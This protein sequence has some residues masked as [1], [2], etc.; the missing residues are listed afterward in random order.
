[1]WKTL[2]G[3]AIGSLLMGLMLNAGA[4]LVLTR[5][6]HM[7]DPASEFE[8]LVR[9]T[10]L[11]GLTFVGTSLLLVSLKAREDRSPVPLHSKHWLVSLATGAFFALA[12]FGPGLV[13]ERGVSLNSP[14]AIA[15]W[16]GVLLVPIAASFWLVTRRRTRDVL[17]EMIGVQN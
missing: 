12:V 10:F 1:M 17:A 11:A 13:A 6:R 14:S 15:A 2:S 8:F 4:L 5:L 7:T 16:M 3:F 9:G